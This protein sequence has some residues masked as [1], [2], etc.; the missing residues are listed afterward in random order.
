MSQQP[1]A[2]P[3]E[4]TVTIRDGLDPSA[5]WRGEW[6]AL[7]QRS[8]HA[9]VF[10]SRAWT[11]AWIHAY[12]RAAPIRAVELRAGGRLVGA[13]WL[14]RYDDP[15][16]GRRWLTVGSGNS[17]RLDPL[18]DAACEHDASKLLLDTLATTDDG[19]SV[20]LQQVNATSVFARTAAQNERCTLSAQ[21][22]CLALDL[23]GVK[24]TDQIL[25][26]GMR[27]DLRRSR[28]RVQEHGGV[29]E[30]AAPETTAGLMDALV[31]LHTARW[32]SRGTSGVL[33]DEATRTLHY[34]VAQRLVN[35]GLVLRAL[36]VDGVTIACV[37]GFRCN[38]V[39]M[40]YLNGFDPEWSWLQPGKLML[41]DSIE[42]AIA[43]GMHR[44]DMLRGHE[45]YKYR[46][47]VVEEP[48][49]RIRIGSN[50]EE[51]GCTLDHR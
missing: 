32:R 41:A 45:D 38:G 30:E 23:T 50:D 48:C 37:Y 35:R 24:S 22:T 25:K 4:L 12:A 40:C 13:L 17:D 9:T 7:L 51:A 21:E 20:E 2:P 16:H 36:Q 14:Y 5:A 27:Y 11:V 3:S 29:I 1:S 19:I 10:A 49:L 26:R 44:F 43:A 18:L 34:S 6:E 8:P 47:P 31:R 33:A 46:W 39:E 15:H 42:R 28:S